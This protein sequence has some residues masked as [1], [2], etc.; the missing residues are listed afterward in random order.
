M[1]CWLQEFAFGTGRRL[2][3][4]STSNDVSRKLLEVS[5]E[6][7]DERQ[8]TGATQGNSG[9]RKTARGNPLARRTAKGLSRGLKQWKINGAIWEV[10]ACLIHC[11]RNAALDELARIWCGF[12]VLDRRH[13]CLTGRGTCVALRARHVSNAHSLLSSHLLLRRDRMGRRSV[14]T[15]PVMASSYGRSRFV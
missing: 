14:R 11:H 4:N 8:L 12:R 13:I 6:A 2:I 10:I 5:N 9:A 7:E 1:T 3:V 15:R